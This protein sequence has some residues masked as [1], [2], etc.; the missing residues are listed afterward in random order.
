[1]QILSILFIHNLFFWLDQFQNY[2]AFFDLVRYFLN[3]ELQYICD[4]RYIIFGQINKENGGWVS[5]YL[6]TK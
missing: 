3:I 5:R 6:R 4:Y 1:M 2:R